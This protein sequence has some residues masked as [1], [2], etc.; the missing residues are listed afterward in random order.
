MAKGFLLAVVAILILSGILWV[1][2]TT[3]KIAARKSRK[4]VMRDVLTKKS[5]DHVSSN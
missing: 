2:Y 4:V 3:G 1:A 5:D